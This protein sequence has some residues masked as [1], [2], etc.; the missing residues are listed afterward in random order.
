M[1]IN[2]LNLLLSAS[3]DPNNTTEK[4]VIVWEKVMLHWTNGMVYSMFWK[5]QLIQRM[6]QEK[7]HFAKL[8]K[9]DY[10][11]DLSSFFLCD[12]IK[13]QIY[14]RGCWFFMFSGEG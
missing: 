5:V 1:K 7:K 14:L 8:I 4:M 11:T 2:E 6:T 3:R 13:Y 10:V 9:F 12:R